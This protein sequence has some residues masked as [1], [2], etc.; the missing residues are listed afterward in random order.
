MAN[1]RV[2][3]DDIHEVVYSKD[4]A[5]NAPPGD[6]RWL[7]RSQTHGVG[8]DADI[9]AVHPLGGFDLCEAL[10]EGAGSRYRDICRRAFVTLNS[11]SDFGELAKL[12]MVQLMRLSDYVTEISSPIDERVAA[13]K[14]AA[15]E[16]MKSAD[17]SG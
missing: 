17:D 14:E 4:P 6:P 10:A 13:E 1:P 11:E 8:G 3:T 15:P 9:V 7:P 5:V 2:R 16:G 12:P